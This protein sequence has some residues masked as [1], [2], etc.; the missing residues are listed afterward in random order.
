LAGE[1][2]F[3]V[4]HKV[5]C[6]TSPEAR[7]GLWENKHLDPLIT[8][9]QGETDRCVKWLRTDEAG[10]NRYLNENISF[11]KLGMGRTVFQQFQSCKYFGQRSTVHGLEILGK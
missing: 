10:Y 5:I 9:L 7:D 8:W 6:R 2:F 1:H 4:D 3:F 11:S